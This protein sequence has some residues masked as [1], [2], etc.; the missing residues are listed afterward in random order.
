MRLLGPG[1][2]G[3]GKA[4]WL[5]AFWFFV[6]NYYLKTFLGE[7]ITHLQYVD[8]IMI[9]SISARRFITCLSFLCQ[10]ELQNC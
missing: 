3:K 8:D 2:Q 1:L 4:F 7:C 5:G 10:K 6:F 9:F